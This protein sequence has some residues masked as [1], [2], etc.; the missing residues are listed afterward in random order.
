MIKNYLY[1]GILS[2]GIKVTNIKLY[3]KKK[4]LTE[5]ELSTSIL[6]DSLLLCFER[7]FL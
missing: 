1:N 3:I 7:I 4:K 6:S 5:L 2:S